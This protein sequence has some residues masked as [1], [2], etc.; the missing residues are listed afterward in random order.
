MK[1]QF[2]I[3]QTPPF[4]EILVSRS[5]LS[6]QSQISWVSTETTNIYPQRKLLTNCICIVERHINSGWC[7]RSLEK[8]M[9]KIVGKE[10][11]CWKVCCLI[12]DLLQ[13][14]VSFF[15]FILAPWLKREVSSLFKVSH[16]WVQALL[17]ILCTSHGSTGSSCCSKSPSPLHSRVDNVGDNG[18]PK[19]AYKILSI[20][21][22]RI[23]VSINMIW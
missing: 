23:G 9:K 21:K 6:R 11:W 10:M 20:L 16:S 17:S 18:V 13:E 7:Y 14:S 1:V 15:A 22:Y 8:L 4:S 5:S 3:H 19:F 2:S 12:E